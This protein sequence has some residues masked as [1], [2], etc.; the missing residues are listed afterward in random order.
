M[1]GPESPLLFYDA[2]CGFCRVAAGLVLA[3]DRGSLLAPVAIQ[4]PAA[5]RWLGGLSEEE[6]MGSWHLVTRDG[7]RHSGGAAF[8][9]LFEILPRGARLARLARRS[10]R[11]AERV[12]RLVAG[13]RERL[14]KLVPDRLRRSAQEA[15]RRRTDGSS[16]EARRPDR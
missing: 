10:P 12:Y 14:V 13:N 5:S 4:D 16:P 6:R 11:A 3:W 8:A 9:P 1:P 7:V 15:L 2:D